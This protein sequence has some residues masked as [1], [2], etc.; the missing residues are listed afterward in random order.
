M[1]ERIVNCQQVG[2]LVGTKWDKY[3]SRARVYGRGGFVLRLP[4]VEEVIT[5]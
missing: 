1:N 4:L 3:E 2:T 5:K